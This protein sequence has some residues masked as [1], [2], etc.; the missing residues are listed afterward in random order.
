MDVEGPDSDKLELVTW[1]LDRNQTRPLDGYRLVFKA[2]FT[3]NYEQPGDSNGDNVYEVEIVVRN[4]VTSGIEARKAVTVE[5]MNI[6]EKGKVTLT[7]SQPSVASDAAPGSDMIT[8][9]LTDDDLTADMVDGEQVHTIT[10]WR[11][12]STETDTDLDIAANSPIGG[13]TTNTFM[14]NEDYVGKFLHAVV[15]YRGRLEFDRRPRDD[16]G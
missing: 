2:G 10:Y 12:Y 9:T 15:E 8:A 1:E 5:V 6:W 4:S 11:W 14:V 16:A 3:P 13:E 7:P